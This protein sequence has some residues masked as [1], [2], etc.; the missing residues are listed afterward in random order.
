MLIFKFKVFKYDW[1]LVA[2]NTT[3]KQF[4]MIVNN[5]QAL[6][7]YVYNNKTIWIGYNSTNYDQWILSGI[8]K[9]LNPYDV[10]EKLNNHISGWKQGLKPRI[11]TYD[12]KVDK[13]KSLQQLQGCMGIAINDFKI[14]SDINRR[15]TQIEITEAIE[16]TTINIKSIMKIFSYGKSDFQANYGL[17]KEFDNLNIW[18]LSK[19]QTQLAAKVLGAKKTYRDDEF[20]VQFPDTLDLNIYTEV[21]NF[22]K[23]VRNYKN[24]YEINIFGVL[25]KFAFGGVHGA[26]KKYIDKGEYIMSDIA[27]MY[28][29]YA[30][31]YDSLSR[32]VKSKYQYKEIRDN[33]IVLK[34]NKNPKQLSL[35]LVLNKTYGGTKDKYSKLY[36]P[37]Q[38]NNIC[39][40]GQLLILDLIEK[41]SPYCKIIQSNTDG[42]LIKLHPGQR[43]N[44]INECNKWSKRTRL[45]LEHDDYI[46]VIQK[47]VNNYIILSKKGTYKSKG[48]YVK[49]LNDLDNDLKIVNIA[50]KNYFI[51]DI[52]PEITIKKCNKLKD[53]QMICK[54]STKYDY[55]QYGNTKI[56][57]KVI[58]VFATKD[59]TAGVY[60]VKGTQ[61]HKINNTPTNCKI[62]NS[63]VNNKRVPRWLSRQWYI[64]LAWSRINDF[65]GINNDDK[66]VSIWELN[67]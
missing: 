66:Q 2:A 53:F 15:L 67:I 20:D 50:I 65:K 58:R 56:N 27:S 32:N 30:I 57:E 10:S 25:H 51:N 61:L 29:A 36:D 21:F 45:D 31:E 37:R 14:Q 55:I 9:G 12:A 34:K 40:G 33:R 13:S 4:D 44:Y 28:P 47:D 19:T 38:A 5:Q 52:D 43:K 7:D 22:Y 26:I 11:I 18:D 63:N 60:R 6:V 41:V 23:N 49:Q 8:M 48:A 62:V 24:Y 35:K 17:I 3:T 1:I 59:A 64:D 42:I 39:V 46:K 54:C 16:Y